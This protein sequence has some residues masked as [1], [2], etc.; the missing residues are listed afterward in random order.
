MTMV[1]CVSWKLRGRG[2]KHD[3]KAIGP[4]H[5]GPYKQMEIFLCE[6]WEATSYFKSKNIKDLVV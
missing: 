4:L 6:Q 5:P 1:L 2:L 3:A